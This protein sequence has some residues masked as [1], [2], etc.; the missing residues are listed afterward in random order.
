MCKKHH[1]FMVFENA[2]VSEVKTQMV[3]YVSNGKTRS[4]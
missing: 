4:K 3:R 2:V 1:L